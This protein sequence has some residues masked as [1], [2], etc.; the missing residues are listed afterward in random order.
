MHKQ[1]FQYWIL[2]AAF[3][4]CALCGCQPTPEKPIVAD[5][6][7]D[8]FW[9]KIQA[10]AA[11]EEKY[12][13]DSS[14]WKETIQDGAGKLSVEIDAKISIPSVEHYPVARVRKISMTE[15]WLRSFLEKLNGGGKLYKFKDENFLTKEEVQER[16]LQ[17]RQNLAELQADPRFAA[18]ME[19][20]TQ[21]IEAEIRAWEAYYSKAPEQFALEEIDVAFAENNA[22]TR[23]FICGLDM[24]RPQMAQLVATQ[25]EQGGYVSLFNYGPQDGAP[26]KTT[27]FPAESVVSA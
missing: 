16:I 27:Q 13:L 22:G 25:T 3:A 20:I 10:E 26:I 1:H 21:E 7:A 2:A 12:E 4:L 8:A 15:A 9:E 6:G 24:G 23:E 17:L 11:P 5:K 19:S 14:I 18:D